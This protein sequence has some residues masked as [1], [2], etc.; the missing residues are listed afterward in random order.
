MSKVKKETFNGSQE[1]LENVPLCKK[2]KTDITN[3]GNVTLESNEMSFS[4]ILE[5][6]AQNNKT[7]PSKLSNI[8]NEIY[9]LYK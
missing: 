9:K 8:R 1:S 5:N 7:A 4:S 2:H 6:G 3:G